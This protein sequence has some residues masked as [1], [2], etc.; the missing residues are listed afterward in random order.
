MTI[1]PNEA[2]RELLE[3]C[4]TRPL[5]VPG[6]KWEELYE[7]LALPRECR[8]FVPL[9]LHRGS[10]RTA[11][12]PIS[13]V[14]KAAYKAWRKHEER[15]RRRST[16][17]ISDLNLPCGADGTRMSH[18]EALDYLKFR[19]IE[20]DWETPYVAQR[21]PRKFRGGERWDED[22]EYTLKYSALIDEVAKLAGLEKER[23]DAVELVL[24]LRG[25]CDSSREQI[26][27]CPPAERKR[28]QAAWKWI[29]R[30][31][32]L[33]AKVLRNQS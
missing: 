13:Y 19:T 16:L 12:N 11:L 1:N 27:A 4:A 31:R 5:D 26:L 21:V 10:W 20:D 9:V 8:E 32:T 25:S 14:R 7:I 18:D 23:R 24:R 33:L 15:L 17:S 28:R 30:N 22:G 3:S 29:D 2:R 6:E